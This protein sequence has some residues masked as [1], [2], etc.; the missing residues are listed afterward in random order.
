MAGISETL[1]PEQAAVVD[2]PLTAR[3]LV[4]AGPGTG[5]THTLVARACS[6][7]AGSEHSAGASVLALS[8]TRSVVAEIE[9]RTHDL[10]G[11]PVSASTI[12]A[13]A[14]KL[15]AQYGETETTSFDRTVARAAKLV[16]DGEVQ[17]HFE[18]ILVDEAQDLV[19][20]VGDFVRALLDS[21]D[22]G[23][24]VFGDPEQ[25]IFDFNAKAGESN[26]FSHLR[27]TDGLAEGALTEN[28]RANPNLDGPPSPQSPQQVSDY[29]RELDHLTSPEQLATL[30]K[31][32]NGTIALLTCTNGE[33]LQWA[34]DLQD[35]GISNLSMRQAATLSAAPRWIANFVNGEKRTQWTRDDFLHSVTASA[36]VPD[37][38]H[39]W[40]EL[41][42]LTQGIGHGDTVT[43]AEIHKGLATARRAGHGIVSTEGPTVSTIHRAK[44][45]EWDDVIVLA[46]RAEIGTG[47]EA[48]QLYVAMTRSRGATLVL[49]RGKLDFKMH[50]L[51]S[52]RWAASTWSNELLAIECQFGDVDAL[53]P[54]S[55][56]DDAIA[57]QHSLGSV[58]APND[59]VDLRVEADETITLVADGKPVGYMSKAFTDELRSHTDLSRVGRLTGARVLCIRSTSGDP[60][61]CEL[62][63][64][65]TTGVWLCAEIYGLARLERVS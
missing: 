39:A 25:A 16:R 19:G 23:F 7:A 27:Q 20:G 49:D 48:R 53:T 2:Q 22:G 10:G 38:A 65:P 5:K 4:I 44:G 8:F 33:G 14:W 37:P 58:L 57:I 24:T 51:R 15:L 43:R 6:L 63:G 30:M 32:Q 28:H 52:K 56:S 60:D 1:T 47:A 61:E 54:V 34:S 11:A 41:R 3:L 31:R 62:A 40:K 29:L 17:V 9:K 42:Q 50:K 46:P 55:G 36:C 26:F 45:L 12:H 59:P 21:T 64:L 13:Y 18:H 35:L